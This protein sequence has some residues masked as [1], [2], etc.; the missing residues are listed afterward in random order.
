MEAKVHADFQ[1]RELHQRCIP[2][3]ST[4]TETPR[5][6]GGERQQQQQQQ[7]QQQKQQKQQQAVAI[8]IVNYV[9]LL[10]N[11][12]A[13]TGIRKID[14]GGF[15]IVFKAT[16][17]E[18]REV[19]AVKVLKGKKSLKRMKKNEESMKREIELLKG[20]RHENIIQ[21]L[22]SNI[23]SGRLVLEFA[24]GGDL[25]K[26]ITEMKGLDE[27]YASHVFKQVVEATCYLHNRQVQHND[28]KPEN[29]LLMTNDEWPVAK[30]T[31]FN[32]SCSFNVSRL[33]TGQRKRFGGT[34]HFS[35]PE[36]LW[37][38]RAVEA[39]KPSQ[40]KWMSRCKENVDVWAI[41]VSLY[42]SC[43]NKRMFSTGSRMVVLREIDDGTVSRRLQDLK[44]S[45]DFSSRLSNFLSI[46]LKRNHRTRASINDLKS[47]N[48]LEITHK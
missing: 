22:N 23:S 7:Q 38:L 41:G 32:L 25:C 2:V 3:R 43:T 6:E 18:S 44:E 33:T 31:D 40:E 24:E 34:P 8:G 35:A 10:I 48:W 9:E 15:G 21:I 17:V 4:P 28:I 13:Y 29:I 27:I 20:L 47:H 37:G 39:G 45:K 36:K 42:E 14:S 26:K 12:K 11:D 5:E 46:C 19:V 30:L 1:L 16:R